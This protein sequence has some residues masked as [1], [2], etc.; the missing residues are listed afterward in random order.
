MTLNPMAHLDP[1][2]IIALL[3]VGFGWARP[4]PVNTRNFTNPRK[5]E[6]IVS[7]A[8]VI[9]NIL[10]AFIATG[11]WLV[12]SV[13]VNNEIIITLI[14]YI[15]VINISLFIFNLI[16]V[17]PLDGFHVAECILSKHIGG[18]FFYNIQRYGHYILIA[19]LI[20]NSRIGVLNYILQAILSGFIRIYMPLIGLLT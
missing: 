12:C 14:E 17:P 1:I 20:I 2:G 5:D 9:T 16:P 18:K 11:L 6:I 7:L 13:Y 3:L 19:V 4:V 10:I 15:V 8:G